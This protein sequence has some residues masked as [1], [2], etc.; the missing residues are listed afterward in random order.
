MHHSQYLWWDYFLR[1]LNGVLLLRNVGPVYC[2]H[3]SIFSTS[4]SASGGPIPHAFPS[5]LLCLLRLGPL[6]PSDLFSGYYGTRGHDG[7]RL[8]STG[9]SKCLE[10]SG[11]PSTGYPIEVPHS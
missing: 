9:L 11:W 7:L 8:N 1:L 10:V 2:R 3:A 5:C 4:I 6:L